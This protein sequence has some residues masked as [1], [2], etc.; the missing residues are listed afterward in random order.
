MEVRWKFERKELEEILNKGY[1]FNFIS[2][3]YK[4]DGKSFFLK[5]KRY[6]LK[7]N[8]REWFIDEYQENNYGLVI[9][10]TKIPKE[11]TDVTLPEWFEDQNIWFKRDING[12]YKDEY[13]DKYYELFLFRIKRNEIM[14]I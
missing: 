5:K 2:I 9:V 6:T 4:I 12:G 10:I 1:P 13:E 7:D 3:E 11:D 14:D 8:N